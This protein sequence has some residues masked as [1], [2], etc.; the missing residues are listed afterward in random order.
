M[1]PGC[2]RPP[3]LSKITRRLHG[4]QNRD[5]MTAR[6]YYNVIQEVYVARS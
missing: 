1:C 4:I 2:L 3:L 6:N 5:M